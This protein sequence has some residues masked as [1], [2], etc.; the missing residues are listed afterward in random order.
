MMHFSQVPY[1]RN[2]NAPIGKMVLLLTTIGRKSGQPR[3]TPLQ[4]EEVDGAYYCGSAR[5][6]EADWYKNIL[7]CPQVE[8]Q[9]GDQRLTA[10]AETITEPTRIADF[11]LLRLE[12]HPRML[13]M[14]MLLEGLSPHPSREQ[15]EHAAQHLALVKL[16]P[17]RL[18]TISIAEFTERGK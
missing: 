17:I 18:E 1:Q 15:L 7:A 13:G 4:Y 12:R 2:P 9:V 10:R 8:L 16:I 5:G 3:V 14:M 11:L 6:T